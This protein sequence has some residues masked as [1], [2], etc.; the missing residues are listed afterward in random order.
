MSLSRDL[1]NYR[2]KKF[3]KSNF[4]FEQETYTSLLENVDNFLITN[5]SKFN[6]LLANGTPIQGNLVTE[7]FRLRKDA[8]SYFLSLFGEYSDGRALVILRTLQTARTKLENVINGLMFLGYADKGGVTRK[9]KII[10]V[11]YKQGDTLNQLAQ[12]FYGDRS[13][14]Y[15]IIYE[16]DEI[17]SQNPESLVG[18]TLRIP[19]E[20]QSSSTFGVF[21]DE[22]AWGRDIPNSMAIEDGDYK[23]LDNYETLTQGV[24]NI[25]DFGIGSVPENRQIGNLAINSLGDTR[26]TADPLLVSQFLQ[27]SLNSDPSIVSSSI[28]DFV[29]EQDVI[30]FN[31]N[32]IPINYSELTIQQS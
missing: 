6:A 31:I 13:Q 24:K 22:K 17:F 10:T 9:N 26:I 5:T 18:K 15:K 3:F 27:A 23:T 2:Q 7:L 14:S 4:I 19:L 25:T 1:S 8:N 30:K 21:S 12:T 11:V 32:I 16:N 29:I 20:V 28:S